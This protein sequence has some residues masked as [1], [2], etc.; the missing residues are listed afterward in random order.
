MKRRSSLPQGMTGGGGGGGDGS[1]RGVS[2]RACLLHCCSS[3]PRI[4]ET[5]KGSATRMINL[6]WNES[7]VHV[8]NNA[9]LT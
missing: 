7:T 5:A 3:V 6:I 4:Q 2:H 9:I 8:R 1:C